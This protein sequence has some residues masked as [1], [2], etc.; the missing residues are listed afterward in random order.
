MHPPPGQCAL[1]L[2]GEP[3]QLLLL[4]LSLLLH[5]SLLPLL[6]LRLLQQPLLLPLG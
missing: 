3:L 4:L 5:L 6:R 1:S 2:A